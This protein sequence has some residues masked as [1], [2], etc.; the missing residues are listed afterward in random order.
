MK[1]INEFGKKFI[2]W[3]S[4]YTFIFLIMLCYLV[5]T[6]NIHAIMLIFFILNYSF[7]LLGFHKAYIFLRPV[8]EKNDRISRLNNMMCGLLQQSVYVK[9]SEEFYHQLLK[10]AIECIEQA[11]KGSIMLMGENNKLYFAA[12]IGYDYEVL[13]HTYLELEQTY[14]YRESKGM[15]NKT[16]KIQNPFEYDRNSF[17]VRNVDDI[18]KAGTDNVMTTLSTPIFFEGKLHG[19]INIDSPYVNAY[20]QYDMD[21]IEMFAIEAANVL[22]L[23]NSLEQVYYMTNYDMLTNVPNRRCMSEKLEL[24]HRKYRLKGGNYTLISIDL[25]NLKTTN[26]RY[27]HLAGDELLKMFASVF[28]KRVPS[29]RTDL[30]ELL[31]LSDSLMYEQKRVYHE[32]NP[33]L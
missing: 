10:G 3:I 19:M 29:D 25:N 18:L 13:K 14:L 7:I 2:I 28:L 26:D 33:S 11:T 17:D 12:A 20:D 8:Y 16:I 27:G 30:K 9:D 5:A 22:K 4:I 21:I 15:V 32:K 1:R 23:Y 6:N 31:H 24:L